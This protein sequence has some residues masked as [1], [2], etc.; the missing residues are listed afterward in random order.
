M[1]VDMTMPILVIDDYAAMRR[2]IRMLLLELGFTNIDQADDGS[3]AL[4]KLHERS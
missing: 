4:A 2:I 3:A 1:A